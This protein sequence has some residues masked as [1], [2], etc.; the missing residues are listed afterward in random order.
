MKS[1]HI[2]DVDQATI[3]ALKRMARHSHRSLQGEVR[4]ILDR[5]ARMAPADDGESDLD[6]VTVE[7][8][9]VSSWRR[10]EVYGDHGR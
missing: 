3:D 4:D 5:A 10:S 6:L 2:R 9:G 8:G 7:I 1:L